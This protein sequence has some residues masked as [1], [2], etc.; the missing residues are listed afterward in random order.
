MTSQIYERCCVRILADGRRRYTGG[1]GWRLVGAVAVLAAAL[2]CWPAPGAMAQD[3][4]SYT[5]ET[6][7]QWFRQYQN[8]KPDFKPGDML[9]AKDLERIRPFVP[10]GYLEQLNFPELRVTVAQPRNHPLGPAY[11]ACTEKYGAQV[12]RGGAGA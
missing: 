5:R 2:L 7:A 9:T 8:A 1:V 12:R 11:T 6:F 10:P 3:L 4:G